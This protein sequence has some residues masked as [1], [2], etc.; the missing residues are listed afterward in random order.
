MS[1]RDREGLENIQV[2]FDKNLQLLLVDANSKSTAEK[3]NSIDTMYNRLTGRLNEQTARAICNIFIYA[4]GWN[5]SVKT[6]SPTCPQYSYQRR[7]TPVQP[8]TPVQQN[9]PAYTQL[10]KTQYQYPP[11]PPKKATK[12]RGFP[13]FV[14]AGVCALVVIIGSVVLISGENSKRSIDEANS[15]NGAINSDEEYNQILTDNNSSE[16]DLEDSSESELEENTIEVT[17]PVPT[18]LRIDSIP[19]SITSVDKIEIQKTSDKINSDKEKK[20]YEFTSTEAGTYRFEFSDVPNNIDFNMYL[21]NADREQLDYATCIA[22][23]EGITFNLDANT[24][25]YLEVEQRYNTGSYVLNIGSAKPIMDISNFTEVS[26]STQFNDQKN[27]YL[28]ISTESGTYRFEFSDVPNNI[29]FNMYLYNADWEQLDY[30]TCIANDEGITFNLDANTQYYLEVEQ[31][32]N[33]GSYV[34]NIGSAK[35]IMDI[36]NY[37]EV[38]DSTQFNDQEN[39]YSFTPVEAGTYRFEFSDIT[40]NIDFNMYLYNA[41]WEQ[42]DYATCIAN[43]EGITFNLDANTQYYLKIQQRYHCGK[44]NLNYCP[45]HEE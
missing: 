16:S 25:Y 43:G 17:E 14:I 20:T 33:T 4:L 11:Q 35:P 3:Q 8:K 32:Y 34:L 29:D 1:P 41:D 42:L 9:P 39:R 18:I 10:K 37:T 36:S 19:E 30:A 27:Q 44:Y 38:S 45:Y 22:N 40:D 26:D 2:A 31:R 5:V 23:G 21:Y 15:S 13:K 7:P 24:Q 28:F 12:T 6:T